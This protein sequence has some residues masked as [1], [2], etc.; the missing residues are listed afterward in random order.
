MGFSR[1]GSGGLEQGGFGFITIIHELGHALGLAH[2]HDKGGSSS[3][4][5]GVGSTLSETM[6]TST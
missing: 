4:F 2:P 1:A 5:P 6:A 3:V